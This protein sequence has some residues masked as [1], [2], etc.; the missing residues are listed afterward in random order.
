VWQDYLFLAGGIV[1][2]AALLPSLLSKD[3]PNWLTSITTSF[4]LFCYVVAYFTLS[5]KFAAIT[6]SITAT[7]WLVMF[8]QKIRDN[9]NEAKTG[10]KR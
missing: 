6:T 2:I 4:F 10:E 1:F 8:V 3:K 9:T 5:L 7:I